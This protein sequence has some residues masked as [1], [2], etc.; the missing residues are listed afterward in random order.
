MLISAEVSL[1]SEKVELSR[2]LFFGSC[3]VPLEEAT[4][5][6][7][8][9][10]DSEPDKAIRNG[11]LLSNRQFG[12]EEVDLVLG[13]LVRRESLCHSPKPTSSIFI[14]VASDKD[15]MPVDLSE[16]SRNKQLH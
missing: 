14:V 3:Q 1:R 16:V 6:V 2:I 15:L 7:L 4:L 9:R 5:I 12:S 8:F 10:A 13:L 11:L